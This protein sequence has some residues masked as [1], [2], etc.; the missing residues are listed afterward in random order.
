MGG[1]AGQLGRAKDVEMNGTLRNFCGMAE[2]LQNI[3]ESCFEDT[4]KDDAGCPAVCTQHG[5][6]ASQRTAAKVRDTMNRLFGMVGEANDAV[7]VCAQVKLKELK[8]LVTINLL[9]ATSS[10]RIG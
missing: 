9:H 2:H 7:L 6:P 1:S 3:D 5:G 8:L 10:Q 4:V